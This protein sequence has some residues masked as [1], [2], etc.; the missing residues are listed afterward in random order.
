M[1]WSIASEEPPLP[2]PFPFQRAANGQTREQHDR[3]RMPPSPSCS[4]RRGFPRDLADRE[5]VITDNRFANQPYVRLRG[6]GL[7]I[8]PCI[9]KQVAVQLLNTAIGILDEVLRKK[10]FQSA[11][12]DSTTGARIEIA[13][14]LQ[15]TSKTRQ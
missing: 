6:A 12:R 1:V 13:A 2:M 5:T 9:P 4:S 11:A 7:L 14:L 3:Y 15:K 10:L 8:H